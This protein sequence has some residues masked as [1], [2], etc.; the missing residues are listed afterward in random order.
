MALLLSHGRGFGRDQVRDSGCL[1]ILL[2]SALTTRGTDYFKTF[3][4]GVL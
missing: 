2:S 1:L 3:L 4:G